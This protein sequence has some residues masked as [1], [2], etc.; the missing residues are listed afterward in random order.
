M[1]AFLVFFFCLVHSLIYV[2]LKGFRVYCKFSLY[3]NWK[4]LTSYRLR[5]LI[6]SV[7]SLACKGEWDGFS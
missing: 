7:S 4:E 5:K 2:D 6:I 3:L 1:L